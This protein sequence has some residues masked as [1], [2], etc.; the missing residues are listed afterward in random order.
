VSIALKAAK[1]FS[2]V[3]R[4]QS[5]TILFFLVSVMV[6]G[7]ILLG[8]TTSHAAESAST[9]ETGTAAQADKIQDDLSS[10]V[11]KTAN[12]I[13]GFF[14]SNRHTRWEDNRTSIRLRFNFDFVEGQSV[15]P[16]AQ[17]KLNLVLP[18]LDNRVRLVMNP[19][20]DD[21]SGNRGDD[22]RDESELALRF[23]GR[24]FGNLQSSYDLG[25]RIK[26]SDLALFLRWNTQ[27]GHDLGHSWHNRFTNQLYWYTD[28]HFRDDFRVYFE[29]RLSERFF[30]RSRTRIQYGQEYGA[31][32]FPEQ[33]FTL[34][35]T[36]NPKHALAYE[37][38]VGVVPFDETIF[39]EDNIDVLDEKYTH[40]ELRLRYRTNM[41]FPWLFFE[42]WPIVSWPEEHDYETTY[43]ARFRVEFHFG[44]LQK[45]KMQLDE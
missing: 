17:V 5:Q 33:R 40:Y 4:R 42:F 41:M 31:E 8:G 44:Y 22:S 27:L 29:R 45:Y 26:D 28:T 16:N 2:P 12:T 32:L 3:P 36:I 11:Q 14:G 30:F 7:A 34:F 10:V 35:Q 25:L 37:A 9:K 39:K 15:D 1:R 13:D 23:M 18:A 38:L 6:T 21:E 43:A 19:D 20:D 24:Q